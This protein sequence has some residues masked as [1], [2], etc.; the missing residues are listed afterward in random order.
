MTKLEL[1]VEKII[2]KAVVENFDNSAWVDSLSEDICRNN[3][4]F[5]AEQIVKPLRDV[6]SKSLLENK[7]FLKEC[8]FEYMDQEF[9]CRME[10]YI[11]EAAERKVESLTQGWR[12]TLEIGNEKE[13]D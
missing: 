3:P 11:Q 2:E 10:E 4:Q 9:D 7:E 5:W 8:I 1:D 6:L 12:V 13:K